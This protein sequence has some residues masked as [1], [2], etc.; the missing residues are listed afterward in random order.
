MYFLISLQNF[1]ICQKRKTKN[2]TKPAVS[3]NEIL[4][5]MIRIKFNE[6]ENRKI[7]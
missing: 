3:R 1:K 4:T 2:Q 5:K 7:Q 6:I